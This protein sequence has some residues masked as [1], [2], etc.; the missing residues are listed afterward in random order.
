MTTADLPFELAVLVDASA[1]P[2]LVRRALERLV[3]QP[4][5]AARLAADP[6]LAA[7]VVA[8][9][10][11]SNPLADVVVTEPAALDV[12]ADLDARPALDITDRATLVR[13]KALEE[14][15]VAARDLLGI[16]DLATTVGA[17]SALAG[18]VLRHAHALEVPD[19]VV[20]ATVAMG[21]FGADE[22]NY[23][24]DV[25]LMFVTASTAD[26]DT[27]T[28]AA[29]RV[30]EAVRPC[31]PVDLNLR[32]QGRDGPMVRTLASYQAYWERWAEPWEFQAL[33]K[34]R[35]IA[36]DAALCAAFDDAAQ[37]AVW[38]RRWSADEIRSLRHLKAR[39]E[40]EVGRRSDG[41]REIKRAPGGIRDVEFSVQLLQ[42]VHGRHDEALRVRATL[43]AIG[44]LAQAGYVDPDDAAVLSAAYRFLRTVE[45]RLQLV[46]L[47]PMYAVP[48]DD[49][50]RQRIAR[51]MGLRDTNPASA[52]EQLDAQ[53]THHQAAVRGVHEQLYFR[54]L[55]EAF[56]DPGL[57]TLAREGALEERLGAFGFADTK[58][59]YAAIQDL[60][61][62]LTRRS[63]L[64][65]QLLPL[66][67]GWLAE[68][69]D[70]D[71][72]LLCLRNLA[73]GDRQRTEEI[74]RSFR[75]SPEAARRLCLLVGTTATVADALR[76]HLDLIPRLPDV[77]RLR[78]A[79]V[80]TL[81]AKA[82]VAIS[83]RADLTD[84]QRGLRRWRARNLVGVVARDVLEHEPVEVVGADLSRIADA[85]MAA[86]LDALEPRIPFTIV[87]L[88]RYGG[89]ELSYASD[90]D[91]VFVHGGTGPD[92]YDEAER[93][94]RGIRRMI[95]G[96]TPAN[97]LWEVDV[98]L[99]PEGKKGPLARSLDAYA[100]YFGQ[101][102]LTWE[103]QA[104]LRARI[105]AG[106]AEVGRR[107]MAL[108]D[109]F[110]WSPGLSAEDVREIRRLKA[111]MEK[112]RIPTGDDPEFHLKLGRGSISDVEWTVQLLQLRHRIPA[113]STTAALGSLVAAGVLDAVDAEH[114]Q[115]SLRSCERMRNRL[116]LIRSE[117]A[118]ALPR[119]PEQLRWL[120]RSLDTTPQ[121]L[122]DDYR[123][124]TR[125]AR[126]VMDRRFWSD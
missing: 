97:R 16:D 72:G 6:A 40:S 39:A 26:L 123:R 11:A 121:A 53:L 58:R 112:E 101:W 45:H 78:T 77:E 46:D 70:P 103:R 99:R 4:G 126:A 88:G 108:L 10:G 23:A 106:D 86:A 79:D 83:W 30:I 7:A 87:A 15:R 73:T 63:R 125:R 85:A 2:V 116:T 81:R 56:S 67:L 120:A 90:L 114:L 118:D 50:A 95:G 110:V 52:L 1:A 91:V 31:Y 68:S 61:R 14:I 49:A 54:P 111:R 89:G 119:V 44:E 94:A 18:D 5:A 48:A 84:K 109:D 96:D 98:D 35:A 64:M 74:T 36:G 82:G 13:W 41:D 51:A 122:R 24:S 17:V 66:L 100:T 9:C 42:L 62:G 57:G 117:P 29:R 105:A 28:R 104:M 43:P 107:F 92:A 38:G 47:G 76:E 25:D 27:A 8:V 69:P 65:Q 60:T 115:A 55:L 59:T 71:L 75:D 37:A 12:L 102:A 34:A 93:L 33:L 113:P 20:L 19:G 80:A 124:V 21:K 22:L 3:A 32:P